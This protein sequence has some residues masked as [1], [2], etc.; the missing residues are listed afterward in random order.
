MPRVTPPKKVK[1]PYLRPL[2]RPAKRASSL[3]VPFHTWR[4]FFLLCAHKNKVGYQR[5]PGRLAETSTFLRLSLLYYLW[6]SQHQIG[7]LS[8]SSISTSRPAHQLNEGDYRTTA[9]T[10]ASDSLSHTH[11]PLFTHTHQATLLLPSF[12][13]TLFCRIA[14][15]LFI[16]F[17][18]VAPLFS[19]IH[20]TS[21]QQ[22]PWCMG[23]TPPGTSRNTV[24]LV[25][26]ARLR[27]GR[28]FGESSGGK[29][30]LNMTQVL[31][32]ALL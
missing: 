8:C 16:S 29:Y 4:V 13:S 22:Y 18:T 27:A 19:L 6:L 12:H 2:C 23:F 11:T 26:R 9:G 30:G 25:Q 3:R 21:F 7:I 20:L 1:I 31:S 15:P 14:A 32:H 24:C 17:F 10:A 5:D 28:H